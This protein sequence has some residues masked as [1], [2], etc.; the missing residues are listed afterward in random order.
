MLTS[1]YNLNKTGYNMEIKFH[2]SQHLLKDSREGGGKNCNL[3]E[4]DF[5]KQY[6]GRICD[7]FNTVTWA[8]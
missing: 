3:G 8:T 1:P 4:R 2:I 6:W 7:Y 5:K